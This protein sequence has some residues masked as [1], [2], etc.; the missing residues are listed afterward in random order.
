[1]TRQS[2]YRFQAYLGVGSFTEFSEM[3]FSFPLIVKYVKIYYAAIV[4][5]QKKAEMPV[6][7]TVVRQNRG[8][9][10]TSIDKVI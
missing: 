1:M 9:N 6:G 8:K 5:Q 2:Q 4:H 3:L 10:N 7:A